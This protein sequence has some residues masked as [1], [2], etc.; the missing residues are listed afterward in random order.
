VNLLIRNGQIW[1]GR[2]F[3]HTDLLIKDGVI[4]HVGPVENG[5]AGASI[6]AQEWPVLPGFIDM[7][8]HLDDT[9]GPYVLADDIAS[10][11][12]C[13][14]ENGITC[15]GTFV[16]ETAEIP[17][18]AAL[19]RMSDKIRGNAYCDVACHVT[20]TRFDD[21]GWRTIEDVLACGIRT[22][23][24]YTTYRKAGL[25][26]GYDDLKRIFAALKGRP[27]RFLVHCEDD[28]LLEAA[29]AGVTDW[30]KPAAHAAAR[31][32]AA[33]IAAIRAVLER[34]AVHGTPVHI[35]HVSTPE[36][37]DL[38]TAA[39]GSQDVMCETGPQYVMLDATWL[40]REN[41]HRWISSPPLRSPAVVKQMLSRARQGTFDVFASDHCPF[42]RENKDADR[43][44]VRNVPNGLPGIGALSHLAYAGLREG[45]EDPLLRLGTMLSENPARAMGLY[46]RKGSLQPGADAD[47]VIV[48]ADDDPHPLRSSLAETWE[49]YPGFLTR[50][51]MHAVLVHGVPVVH[52][53]WLLDPDHPHGSCTWET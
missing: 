48:S 41:G 33:E 34:A 38:I 7:H 31:P 39:K 13:A 14:V 5:Y 19:A 16:T 52:D 36:G 51:R 20:P 29:A 23:K 2:E 46:P 26:T 18:T 43:G 42:H 37:A 1:Q 8:T 30:S 35:V 32:P 28:L 40:D 9:I 21:A 49:P 50:I 47:I 11:T 44:D 15:V 24:L 12:R 53:G 45:K 6:D 4:E 25:Y 3:I 10:G 27:L 17:L 22:I